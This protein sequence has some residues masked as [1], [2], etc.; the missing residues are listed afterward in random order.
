MP[1][2]LTAEQV[3]EAIDPYH[4]TRHLVRAL[5]ASHEALRAERDEAQKI[6]NG[7][8]RIG[9]EEPPHHVFRFFQ[10]LHGLPETGAPNGPTWKERAVTAERRVAE[11]EA[12]LITGDKGHSEER[13]VRCGW[14][15]GQPP[16]NCQNDDTPHR[17]PSQ[18]EESSGRT[19]DAGRA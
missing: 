12:A 16:L 18:D 7:L 3:A 8:E 5:A 13:C 15:M 17:F 4:E 19:H 10:R 14:T 11:L 6:L 2:V 9:L 1:T